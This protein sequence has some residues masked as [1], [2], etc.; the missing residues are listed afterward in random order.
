MYEED[1]A[2]QFLMGLNDDLYST[3]QSQ[4]LALDPLPPL[5]KIFNMTQ[6]EESHKKIMM[7]R[8]TQSETAMAFAAREQP[9]MVEKQGCKICGRYGHEEAVCYEVI[10]YPPGWGTRGRGRG[11]KGAQNSRGERGGGRR[12]GYGRETTAAAIHQETGP[13][14]AAGPIAVLAQDLA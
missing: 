3:L 11:S 10:G 7:A 2:H 1:R 6:Q 9:G 8:D 12:R 14:A 13:I 4:I 5:D